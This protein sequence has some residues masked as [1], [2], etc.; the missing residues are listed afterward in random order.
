MTTSPDSAVPTAR[1]TE[2]IAWFEDLSRA[3][4]PRVGGKGANL[5]ELAGAGLPV[6]AGFVITAQAYLQ[7]M[8]EA[9]VR[10][11]MQAAASAVD[12]DSAEALSSASARLQQMVHSAGLP[13]P[14]ERAVLDAYGRLDEGR[15]AVRSSATAEDAASTSFA[16]MNETFT[17]VS[18]GPELLARVVDCWASLFGPRVVAYRATHRLAEEPAIAVV[19]QRMVDSDASGV[20]FT[21]DPATGDRGTVVV[22]A[23]YGLGEVVVGGQV[24]PDT[25]VVAKDGPRIRQ[26]HIGTK[27]EQIVRGPDGHDQRLP[28]PADLQGRRVLDDDA[29]LTLARMAMQIENHYGT[30]QDVEFAIEGG[31][32]WVVQSRPITTLGAPGATNDGEVPGTALLSGLAAAP[33]TATGQVRILR[34]TADGPRLM[35]GEVL[36][37][38]MTNPDWVPTMRRAAAL[39][40]DGGGVTCHAAIVGRELHLPTIVGTR[41]AT[42]VLRDGELVT[43]DGAKGVVYAGAP[44][45]AAAAPAPAALVRD[46]AEPE[47][48]PATGAEATGTLLYVNLAI[49]DHAEAVAA[50]PVDGVGLL[51]AEFMITDALRGEHP[52]HLLAT[53]RR[54]KFVETMSESVLR[55]TRAFAPRPVVYR[56]VDFRTNEFRGLTGGEEFEP[57]EANPMIGYRGCY[58]YIRDPELFALDLDVVAR[59][60]EQTPNLHLMIPFVRTRWELEACLEAVDIHA[61]G[62]QRGLHRWV[63]A[64]VP[65]V[66]YRI[67][68][69][70]LLGVDGVSIGSNDLTQLMLGVDRDSEI[71][72]ELFDESDAA[73]VDAIERII[74]ACREAGITSSLCGQAP[75]NRP[76]FAEV[77]VRAGITS[78]SVNPDAA[79][80]ARQVIA[81]VERRMLL[82]H[83]RRG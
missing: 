55:I 7:A 39:V 16:G 50:M 72:A 67:P 66:V 82:D 68:E 47:S 58:R 45:A 14:L 38:S 33:G 76:E 49:A 22:E 36:V 59:V 63:M 8:E 57:V 52:K 34:S 40:T 29:V 51:R 26:V 74:A 73:V 13:A 44:A 31:Q 12:V 69:Y 19:V 27:A 21:A 79:A 83:V 37:A 32:T 25:Y 41:H 48:A 15:V 53:G 75:S 65:S 23:A 3:D 20:M 2:L 80:R 77:L 43:V 24:S 71:C 11:A 6:P 42:T 60:R 30:P 61:L 5:G 17:N 70:A 81:R 56:A 4:V 18:G 54:A 9:G 62:R 46:A 35:A 1:A 78:I 10:E 28:V 64:E